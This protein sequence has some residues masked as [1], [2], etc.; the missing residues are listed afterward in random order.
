MEQASAGA[1]R[2]PLPDADVPERIA[3]IKHPLDVI[4]DERSWAR[5]D[6]EH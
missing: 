5:A 4:E 3:E 6:P 1:G 2:A